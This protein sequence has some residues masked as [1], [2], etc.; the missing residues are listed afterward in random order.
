[1]DENIV[2][3]N[4]SRVTETRKTFSPDSLSSVRI[5][6]TWSLD[7]SS[8]EVESVT[9]LVPAWIMEI[10]NSSNNILNA[11]TGNLHPFTGTIR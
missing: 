6:G 1:M 9:V 8:T 7:P 11:V 4:I 5:H 3:E 10:P 2:L